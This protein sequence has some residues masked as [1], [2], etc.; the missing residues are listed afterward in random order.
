[1]VIGT[2][3]EVGSAIE[4]R[5]DAA[6]QEK[7]NNAIAAAENDNAKYAQTLE[8][9]RVD[10]AKE[11]EPAYALLADEVKKKPILSEQAIPLT[12]SIVAAEDSFRKQNAPATDLTGQAPGTARRGAI[13]LGSSTTAA[14]QI[15]G[16][17]MQL[18]TALKGEDFNKKRSAID[19]GKQ[20][21]SA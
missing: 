21:V 1:M 6:K 8:Q 13:D 7:A 15:V 12:G 4:T 2:G 14:N 5:K 19:I 11:Y 16:Q 18:N 3:L 20:Y 17:T 9:R 10:N